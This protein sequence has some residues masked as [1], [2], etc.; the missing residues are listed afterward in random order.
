VPITLASGV[1][2]GSQY[3][4]ASHSFSNCGHPLL[5]NSSI[6]RCVKHHVSD[7]SPISSSRAS[8]AG[9]L[10]ELSSANPQ[11]AVQADS[12]K[13]ITP[14]LRGSNDIACAASQGDPVPH[15]T[16]AVKLF[17]HPPACRI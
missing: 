11:L 9:Y 13:R 2:N 15:G 14:P 3:A 16:H 1:L 4:T 10:L 5:K 6:R 12:R 7:I 17:A 8:L